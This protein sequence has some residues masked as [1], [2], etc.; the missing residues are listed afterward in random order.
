MGKKSFREALIREIKA[1]LLTFSALDK[2]KL[3]SFLET[4]LPGMNMFAITQLFYWLTNNCIQAE[5]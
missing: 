3:L 1:I 2:M 4:K 5:F